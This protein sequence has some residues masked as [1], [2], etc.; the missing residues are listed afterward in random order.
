MGTN[1]TGSELDNNLILQYLVLDEVY[2]ASFGSNFN[3]LFNFNKV[4]GWACWANLNYNA[5]HLC[6]LSMNET[7][8]N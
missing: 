5:T 7:F 2:S 1:K 8:N 6:H 4:T 3:R